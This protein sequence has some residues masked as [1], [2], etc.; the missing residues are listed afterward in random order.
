MSEEISLHNM[1]H[2]HLSGWSNRTQSLCIELVSSFKIGFENFKRY[3]KAIV[4][5]CILCVCLHKVEFNLSPKL[6]IVRT[7]PCKFSPLAKLLNVKGKFLRVYRLIKNLLVNFVSA[8]Q[9]I[10]IDFIDNVLFVDF[11]HICCLIFFIDFHVLFKVA[12]LIL[13]FHLILNI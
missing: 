12:A 9:R 8:S 2:R 3:L 11:I 5:F 7:I 13:R 4:W 6:L 10:P 1:Y